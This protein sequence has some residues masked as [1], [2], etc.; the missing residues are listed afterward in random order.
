M[1]SLAFYHIFH[2]LL[3]VF[4]TSE[5]NDNSTKFLSHFLGNMTEFVRA[6]EAGKKALIH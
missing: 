1:L 5:L 4:S 2:A 6:A 3:L